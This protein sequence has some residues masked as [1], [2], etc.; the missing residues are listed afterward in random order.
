MA[1]ADAV[2]R[3]V[4]REMLYIGSISQLNKASLAELALSDYGDLHSQGA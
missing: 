1:E 3:K 2:F 4:L